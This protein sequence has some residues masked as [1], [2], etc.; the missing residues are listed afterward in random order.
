MD[1][2]EAHLREVN[3]E[4][5]EHGVDEYEDAPAG[6]P[7]RS[8]EPPE[9]HTPEMHSRQEN[10]AEDSLSTEGDCSKAIDFSSA[11]KY[12]A[13]F[14]TSDESGRSPLTSGGITRSGSTSAASPRRI[15]YY[16]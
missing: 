15:P 10:E 7:G 9:A 5:D 16:R 11:R 12:K 8:H 1:K 14:W 6:G 3:G 4:E 2:A 13:C